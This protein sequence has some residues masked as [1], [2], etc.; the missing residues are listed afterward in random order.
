MLLSFLRL[1][2]SMY[3]LFMMIDGGTHL[4]VG[5]TVIL[6]TLPPHRC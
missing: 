3:E 4:A 6:L 1:Y 2:A 5:E